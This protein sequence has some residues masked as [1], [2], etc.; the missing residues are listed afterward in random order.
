MRHK[1]RLVWIVVRTPFKLLRNERLNVTPIETR[2][3]ESY[4]NE[5]NVTKVSVRQTIETVQPIKV[6]TRNANSFADEI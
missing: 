1:H 5:T 4:L 2:S 3:D 6:M